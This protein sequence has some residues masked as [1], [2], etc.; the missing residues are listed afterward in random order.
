M[1][2]NVIACLHGMDVIA[3]LHDMVDKLAFMAWLLASFLGMDER[4]SEIGSKA[5]KVHILDLRSKQGVDNV[6]A[7]DYLAM[8]VRYICDEAAEG[9]WSAAKGLRRDLAGGQDPRPASKGHQKGFS[10]LLILFLT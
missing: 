5:R 4:V 1:A 2:W 8:D 3:Y 10:V 7:F 9:P 6:G